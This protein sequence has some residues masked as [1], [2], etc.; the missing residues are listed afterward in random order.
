LED[1]TA[2]CSRVLLEN[3]SLRRHSSTQKAT[4][5]QL[6]SVAERLKVVNKELQ[7]ECEELRFRWEVA[8]KLRGQMKVHF[9]KY[10]N[11]ALSSTSGTTMESK[12]EREES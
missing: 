9:Q 11:K 6:E 12:I 5:S 2:E 3:Q 4:I 1:Q 7:R 8:E 10:V